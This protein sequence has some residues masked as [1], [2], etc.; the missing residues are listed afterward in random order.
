MQRARAGSGPGTRDPRGVLSSSVRPIDWASRRA[1]S[2]VST[3]TVRPRSAARSASAAAV[4][5]LPTPPEP[6]QTMMLV[7]RSSSSASTSSCRAPRALA[8]ARLLRGRRD[9]QTAPCTSSSS[10]SSCR[11]A[12]VHAVV[13]QRQ[14]VRSAAAGRRARRRSRFSSATRAA[15]LGGL[16]RAARR[17]RWSSTACPRLRA[18]RTPARAVD[19]PLPGARSDRTCRI[20]G[21]A[22][23][24]DDDRADRQPGGAQLRDAVDRLLHRHLLEQRDE[25]HGG[26][27]RSQQPA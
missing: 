18:R 13:Q 11:P 9:H 22:D 16:A 3:H 26:L 1:G 2:M 15:L 8:P 20:S 10:A 17:R 19:V 14:L 5:V 27:R 4:V 6:Q 23:H 24:V 12:E 21:G 7:P 25:V